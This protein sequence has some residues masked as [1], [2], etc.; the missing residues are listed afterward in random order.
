VKEVLY[1]FKRNQYYKNFKTV[2]SLKEQ[3]T[4]TLDKSFKVKSQNEITSLVK[5]YTS[6]FIIFRD[7]PRTVKKLI[8]L[9]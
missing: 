9:F 7:H 3:E 2:K 4:R 6:K 8:L 1:L 5:R